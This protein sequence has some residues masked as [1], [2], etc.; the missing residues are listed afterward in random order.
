M[1]LY[2]KIAIK[3]WLESHPNL[4]NNLKGSQNLTSFL[5]S[6]DQLS[7]STSISENFILQNISL[8]RNWI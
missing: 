8:I 3:K 7:E 6:V 1:E 5:Y 4:A 2:N